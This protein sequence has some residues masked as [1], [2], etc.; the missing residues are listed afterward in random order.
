MNAIVGWFAK[1]PVAA[2]ILMALLIIGGIATLPS[3]RV[4]VFP[5]FSADIVTVAVPYP[6]AAPEE[7]DEAIVVRV[8]EELQDVDDVENITATATEG[9]GSI[10]VQVRPGADARKVLDDVKARVD[11]IDSF[12]DD[13]EKPVITEVVAR[14]QVINVAVS[15]EADERSLKA[16]GESVRA[17][18]LALPEIT[19]V[20]ISAARPYEVS[21]EVSESA[22]RRFGLSIDDVAA[23][24]R[25]AA[26]DVPGGG[27]KTEG[28]EVLL[29]AKARA[30][31][32]EEIADLPVRSLPGG[33][34]L[35]VRDVARVIDG[36]EDN[37]LLARFDGAPRRTAP[38]LPRRRRERH[39]DRGRH[40]GLRRRGTVRYA[41]RGPADHVARR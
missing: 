14:A 36:F 21:V 2:N 32:G 34:R 4:E 31:S 22:L 23:A 41:D 24:L 6:G 5:E 18:L 11:A 12:P 13:A 3:V 30:Y 1:N 10:T 7:V 27:I 16:L 17:E 33:A 28:G 25:S 8:T 26:I 15:G 37:D 40:Q 35:L 29:R 38:G 20:V 19:Q 9:V 39:R